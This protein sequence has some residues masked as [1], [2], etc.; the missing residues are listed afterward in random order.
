M[1]W[2]WDDGSTYQETCLD[3]VA[4]M[5]GKYEA[6]LWL[7]GGLSIYGLVELLAV[8]NDKPSKMPYAPTEFFY[9]NL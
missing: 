3:Q 4:P 9:N 8:W 7:C 2:F 1:S 5:A 6:L